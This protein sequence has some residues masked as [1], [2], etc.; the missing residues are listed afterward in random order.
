MKAYIEGIEMMKETDPSV[1]IMVTEPLVHISASDPSDP[2]LCFAAQEK[3]QEQFQV[4]DI[5]SGKMCPEL[6]GKEEY[7]DI[8]GVNFYFNNQWTLNE[9]RSIPGIAIRQ[10]PCGEA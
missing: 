9:H 6:R 1:R 3:H 10:T 8:I 4:L 2:D 7:L 5:L